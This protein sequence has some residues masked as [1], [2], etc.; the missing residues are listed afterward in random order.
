MYA[1]RS[2]YVGFDITLVPR[3]GVDRIG[4]YG[5]RGAYHA[6]GY[7]AKTSR[8]AGKDRALRNGAYLLSF[9]GHVA[10]MIDGEVIDWTNRNNFV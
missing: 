7:T 2:Y 1:I 10:G 6:N 3:R 9:C 4:R 8:T 5:E